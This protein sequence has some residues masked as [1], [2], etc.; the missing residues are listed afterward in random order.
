MSKFVDSNGLQYFWN[1]IKEKLDEK[2]SPADLKPIQYNVKSKITSSVATISAAYLYVSGMTAQ[3]VVTG[4]LNNDGEAGEMINTLFTVDT[5]L[6]PVA[7]S[8]ATTGQYGIGRLATGGGMNMK[9]V[10]NLPSTSTWYATST[11]ILK[12]AYTG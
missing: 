7:T 9:L 5:S 10:R 8:I 6:A 3:L 4:K 1:K 12:N 11:Y 2:L